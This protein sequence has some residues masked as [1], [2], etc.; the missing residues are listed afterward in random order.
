MGSIQS[1]VGTFVRT[2]SAIAEAKPAD[3]AE[4][5]SEEAKAETEAAPVTDEMWVSWRGIIFN[6]CS[7]E[8]NFEI[9]RAHV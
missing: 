7:I 5:P 1:P 3:G 8:N 9:G 2:L 6:M 4:A